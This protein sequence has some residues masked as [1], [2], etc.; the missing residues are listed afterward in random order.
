MDAARSVT[1][2]VVVGAIV[3]TPLFVGFAAHGVCIRI[4]LLRGLAAPIHTPLFGANKTYRGVVAVAPGDGSGFC[5]HTWVYRPASAYRRYI[6]SILLWPSAGFVLSTII[7]AAVLVVSVRAMDA[8]LNGPSALGGVA[9]GAIVFIGPFVASAVGL[10]GGAAIGVWRTR[11]KGRQAAP[12][13][14][15]V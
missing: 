13:G 12:R 5:R 4:G 2:E 9:M 10:A 7:Y 15:I 1:S 11:S 6:T 8:L 3:V 14:G